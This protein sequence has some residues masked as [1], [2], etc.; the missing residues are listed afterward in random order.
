MDRQEVRRI[1]ILFAHNLPTLR[2]K[3]EMDAVSEREVSSL[4]RHRKLTPFFTSQA[5]FCTSSAVRSMANRGESFL[6]YT[7]KNAL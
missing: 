5:N 3:S 1:K 4:R 6:R 2:Q 7:L